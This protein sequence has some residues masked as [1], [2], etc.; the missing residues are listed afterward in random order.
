M[1][2]QRALLTAEMWC[3]EV[4]QISTSW[5]TDGTSSRYFQMAANL[6]TADKRVSW[7]QQIAWLQT[8]EGE[9]YREQIRAS[10]ERLRTGKD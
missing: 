6:F 3:R 9:R 7:G 2:I 4:G 5:M 1:R 10:A 8:E